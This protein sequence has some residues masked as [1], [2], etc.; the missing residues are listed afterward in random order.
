MATESLDTLLEHVKTTLVTAYAAVTKKGLV[1]RAVADT[2]VDIRTFADIAVTEVWKEY[3]KKSGLPIRL[4]TE[5]LE[6]PLSFSE[7]PV[8][9]AVGDEVDGTHNQSSGFGMLPH[10][11]VIGIS[12]KPDPIF[13]SFL[14]TGFL[15]FNSG[16]LFYAV[17]GRGAYLIEG[18]ARGG[19][20]EKRLITSDRTLVSKAEN[21]IADVYMLNEL[22]AAFLPDVALRGGDFRSTAVHLALV[23]AGSLDLFVLGD[24]CPNPKKRRTGEEI[25]PGYLLVREAGGAIVDWRGRDLGSQ[26]VN[27]HLKR[28][29]H[30]VAAATPELAESYVNERIL[31]SQQ[32]RTYMAQKRLFTA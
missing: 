8:L 18:W 23:A 14:V 22:A 5:E 15:E 2:K 17:K 20:E 12:D 24:N 31:A 25:G 1:A 4:Y 21:V 7:S 28:T 11:S 10:G 32:I 6:R 30:A 9:S 29:F 3:F 16:N 19:S 26:L 27:L 13:D